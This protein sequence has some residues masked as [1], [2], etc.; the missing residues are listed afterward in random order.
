MNRGHSRIS[1]LGMVTVLGAVALTAGLAFAVVAHADN[2]S[3][4]TQRA[5]SGIAVR[6][7]HTSGSGGAAASADTPNQQSDQGYLGLSVTDNNGKLTVASVV[8][9]GPADKADVKQGD[10]ITAVGGTNVASYADLKKA[11]HGK[12]P[13][14]SVTLAITRG[15]SAQNLTVTLGDA[16]A[17]GL[18]AK[19][20]GGP[21]I[22]SLPGFAGIGA[23]LRQGF[24]NFI[25]VETKTKDSNG[26]VHTDT[27]VGGTVKSVSG[28]QVTVTLNSGSGDQT[29]SVDSN[30]H[31]LKGPHNGQ[32][33]T[34]G[35]AALAQGDKVLVATRDGSTTASWILVVN[36]N[37]GFFGGGRNGKQSQNQP[38]G[39]SFGP[40]G[41]INITLPGGQSIS[42]P[43]AGN[44]DSPFAP[45]NGGQS[46][47]SNSSRNPFGGGNSRGPAY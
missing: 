23:A 36:P 31:V 2:S 22:G 27:V 38:G 40:N 18:P 33:Q 37:G 47:G 44:G 15:G 17:A 26:Q 34:Q 6:T 32:G 20:N 14:D 11:L 35:A 29:F 4:P 8:A 10:V 3:A 30:T 5:G 9:G 13:G 21:G 28:N 25:S 24:D 43:G 39:I 42:V 1:T 45:P 41:S 19:P 46:G 7:S 12:H 16:T